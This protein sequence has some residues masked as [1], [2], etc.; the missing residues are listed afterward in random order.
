MSGARV[1]SGGGGNAKVPLGG[2]LGSIMGSFMW[3]W[4]QRLKWLEVRF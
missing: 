4:F 3:P 1:G 2:D